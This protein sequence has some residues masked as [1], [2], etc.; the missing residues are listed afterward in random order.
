MKYLERIQTILPLGYLYLILLGLLKESIQFYQ[1]GINILSFSSITDILIS[2]VSDLAKYPLLLISV[3]AILI[4]LFSFQALLIRN[5]QKAW[6]QKIL[7]E[8]RFNPESTSKEIQKI[9]LPIVVL[10]FGFVL[11]SFFV[12]L[13]IGKGA[14]TARMIREG[15]FTYNYRLN[16]NSGKSL[17]AYVFASNSAYFF[18]VTKDNKNVSIIPVAVIGSL[19]IINN[20]HL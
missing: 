11:L 14:G 17:D 15:N 1:L 18:Y 12:G 16:F 7:G 20:K 4:V 8:N 9:T 19:E 6:A 10:A 13:G 2:P 3:A 5:S